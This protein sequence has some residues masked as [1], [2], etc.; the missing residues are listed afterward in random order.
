M[1]ICESKIKYEHL[2]KNRQ[3]MKKILLFA[4]LAA[5]AFTGCKK[6]DGVIDPYETFKTDATPRWE[7]GST[8]ER[9][10]QGAYVFIT[11]TGGKLFSSDNY[12]TGRMPADGSDYELIEFSGSPAV[13]TP[14]DPTIRKPSGSAAL[15]SLEI[16][17]ITGDK[18]WIVFKETETST[19]RRIVQ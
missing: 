8:V 9:N 19:E 10:D 17:Q 11:D 12:K 7:N 14:S 3:N 1:E 15:H 2:I 13:G 4:V 5:A 18:L 16:V 6:D